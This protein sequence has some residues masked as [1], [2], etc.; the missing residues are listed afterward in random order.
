MERSENRLSRRLKLVFILLHFFGVVGIAIEQFRAL[1]L[2]MSI[3]TLFLSF[4]WVVVDAGTIR[5]GRV[6]VV[7]IAAFL[8]ELIGISTGFP[9]GEYHYLDNL[10]P[11]LLGTPVII[12]IN[13]LVMALISRRVVEQKFSHPILVA[14]LTGFLMTT[15]DVLIEP[16]CERLGYWKWEAGF[17]PIQNFIAWWFFGSIFSIVLGSDQGN[18]KHANLF[19]LVY[20]GFFGIL[21]VIL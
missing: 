11:K 12:G 21:N 2:S 15:I 17:A 8:L 18:S 10:G 20:L 13:W 1:F 14:W 5:W 6:G 16:I 3:L 4:I 7:F 19:L 9:F